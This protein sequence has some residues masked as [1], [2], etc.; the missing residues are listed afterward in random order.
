MN[1]CE[2]REQG[3][4]LIVAV[5][6]EVDLSW[7]SEV[8]GAILDALGKNNAVLVELEKVSY[9]DSSGIAALVEGYQTAKSKGAKFGLVSI[10]GAVQAVLELARLDQVFPIYADVQAAG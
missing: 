5:S 9:I 10:S 1:G 2:A 4:Y 3:E 8:R 7:S 6:G